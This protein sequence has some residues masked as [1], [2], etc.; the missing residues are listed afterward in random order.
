MIGIF[1]FRTFY[2]LAMAPMLPNPLN[3]WNSL[4]AA[5]LDFVVKEEIFA[6]S[7]VVQV[8]VLCVDLV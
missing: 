5:G 6:G 7:V 4:T 2:L 8:R 3:P 1:P